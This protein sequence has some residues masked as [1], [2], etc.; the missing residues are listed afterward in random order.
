[1]ARRRIFS[2]EEILRR[3]RAVFVEFG[4]GARTKQISAAVGLTWGAIALRFGDK[5]KLFSRAMAGPILGPGERPCE[6]APGADL[7]GLLEGLRSHLWEWWPQRL[8][9]R[10]ATKT[11][12][13][14]S[15]PDGLVDWLAATL[16]AHARSGEV[17][18]DMST[19]ALA[20]AVVALLVGD[21]AQRFVARE[22]S[23]TRDR[24]FV[25]RVVCLL[26]GH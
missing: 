11:V 15:E 5:R 7:R 26:S 21:V 16:E 22:P 8:Q 24:T 12:D 4:F 14:D 18:S 6:P 10:L 3:A 9:Y 25:D 1:M 20:Q 19:D 17:R 2:D 13:L 23:P